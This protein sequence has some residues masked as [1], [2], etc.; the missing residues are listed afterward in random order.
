ME[1]TDQPTGISNRLLVPD[2]LFLSTIA[3]VFR[4]VVVFLATKLLVCLAHGEDKEEGVR[5]ARHESKQFWLVN[6]EDVMERELLRETK[7]VDERGHDIW[8]VFCRNISALLLSCASCCLTQRNEPLLP[9]RH[10]GV[11]FSHGDVH[12]REYA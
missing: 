4:L 7:L 8:I 6:A 5:R 3:F 10:V 2:N 12:C 9:H 11:V 1:Q